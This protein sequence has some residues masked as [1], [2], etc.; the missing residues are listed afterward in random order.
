MG[1]IRE[2]NEPLRSDVLYKI[3]FQQLPIPVA[4]VDSDLVIRDANAGF[5]ALSGAA[6]E[7]ILGAKVALEIATEA[8]GDAT[9]RAIDE[10]REL[11]T[12]AV[13]GG[14]RVTLTIRGLGGPE[15]LALAA[16]IE[17]SGGDGRVEELQRAIRSIKHEM[18]NPLTGALGNI[19]L[20]MRR[21]DLDEKSRR[22]LATAAQELKKVSD[23]VI[24]LSELA[25]TGEPH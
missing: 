6:P 2:Q 1:R 13:L 8:G 5:A 22:R 15:R 23:L 20:L 9:R 10:G 11:L 3:L 7:D 18:N 17:S 16:V 21:P 19:T 14:R 4:I 12:T 25:P 24:Q